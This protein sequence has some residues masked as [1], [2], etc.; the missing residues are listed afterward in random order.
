M[1]TQCLRHQ[2]YG[3]A[4]SNRA[5]RVDDARILI[6]QG[7]AAEFLALDFCAEGSVSEFIPLFSG[8][9]RTASSVLVP[10][11]RFS[12]SSGVR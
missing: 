11:Q 2:M 9:D 4:K 1:K 6:F 12:F 10:D 3:S 5:V 7:F 8:R